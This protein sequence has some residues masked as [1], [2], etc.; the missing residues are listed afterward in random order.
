MIRDDKDPTL[1]RM[2]EVDWDDPEL[3]QLLE[4]TETLRLD[5]RGT[6]TASVVHLRPGA[7]GQGADSRALL[8]GE[9]GNRLRL[10]FD[11]ALA[12]GRMIALNRT[13]GAAGASG[14]ELCSVVDC[15]AGSRRDD[16]SRAVFVIELQVQR[17]HGP[18][19]R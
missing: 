9:T 6:H 12:P 13:A 19:V 11:Q 8:V 15:R 7:A 10:L 17:A 1:G 5:N 2:T 16:E 3:R 4:S 14:W 18:Y